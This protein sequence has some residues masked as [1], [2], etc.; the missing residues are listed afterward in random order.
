VCVS[1]GCRRD[2]F[3]KKIAIF[4]CL[5]RR[6][7]PLKSSGA[8]AGGQEA[9]AKAERG[10]GREKKKKKW[11]EKETG[12]KSKS[13]NKPKDVGSMGREARALAGGCGLVAV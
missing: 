5:G 7:W 1:S 8:R 4:K 13:A 2:Q 10:E 11:S 3:D 9:G 6:R 12:K